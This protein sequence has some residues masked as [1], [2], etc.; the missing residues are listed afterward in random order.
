VTP[1][2]AF[3]LWTSYPQTNWTVCR[4]FCSPA[5]VWHVETEALTGADQSI[6][7]YQA[8]ALKLDRLG[9][10]L[11]TMRVTSRSA[12]G[13]VTA[14]VGAGGELADVRIDP[15]IAAGLDFSAVAGRVVEAATLAAAEARGRRRRAVS[16]LLPDHLRALAAS[17][18]RDGL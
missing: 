3:A 1:A 6:D 8:L 9:D 14:T 10:E 12:D 11:A 13:C 17:S 5:N 15:E 16:G 2:R 7:D 4:R 18:L